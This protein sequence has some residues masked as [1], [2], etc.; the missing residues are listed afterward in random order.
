M[1]DTTQ[2]PVTRRVR[3][4]VVRA[5]RMGS[6]QVR[7][8][9]TLAPHYVLPYAP[10]RLD[11]ASVFGRAAPTVVE[12][13]FGMGHATADWAASHPGVNMIGIEV[14]P[15][16]VGAL[17]QRIDAAQ[18]HNLRILQ[19]DA[20]EVFEHMIAP[21]SLDA[22]HLLFPDPWPK[23]R[24]HKRRL[25]Q[26]AFVSLLSSTLAPGGVLHMA[27]D[28]EPYAHH[29]MAVLSAEPQLVNRHAGFAPR[30]DERIV[31]NFERRGLRLGHAVWDVAFERRARSQADQR[32]S[33]AT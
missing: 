22:V 29:M 8:L 31:T 13:G 19:H 30:N 15:P 28:W 7:A 33:P 16:G 17:L 5:G 2:P 21:Q 3:S 27:T 25:V 20:V 12:I 18:L 11:V 1:S 14:H 4:Y 24:H 32:P 10:A 9:Q 6:G 23:K 26:P